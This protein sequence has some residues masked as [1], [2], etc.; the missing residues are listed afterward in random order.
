MLVILWIVGALVAIIVLAM[1]LVPMFIDEQALLELASSS[2]ACSSINMGTSSI[3]KT[4]IATSAPTI[5]RI[6]SILLSPDGSSSRQHIKAVRQG[7][8]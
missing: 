7:K 8:R 6:T 3:A 5:Q 2:S 1:L 4:M